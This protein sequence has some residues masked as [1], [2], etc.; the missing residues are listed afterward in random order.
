MYHEVKMNFLT[1][2]IPLTPAL[3]RGE[4]EQPFT[5]SGRSV[6]CFANPAADFAKARKQ[7]LPLP[8]GEG[9]GEG[10]RSH[11]FIA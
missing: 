9:R 1:A 3:S 7:F 2:T 11:Y 10:E 6:D 5:F 8:W 4:R